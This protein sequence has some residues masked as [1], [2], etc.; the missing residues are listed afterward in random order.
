MI[1]NFSLLK[2][3]TALLGGVVVSLFDSETGVPEITPS[4]FVPPQPRD[5]SALPEFKLPY[6]LVTKIKPPSP[7]VLVLNENT[8]DQ[9]RSGR[10]LILLYILVPGPSGAVF[11]TAFRQ[12]EFCPA[13]KA[14]RS[15]LEVA[16][17]KTTIGD[18]PQIGAVF[19]DRDPLTATMLN[20]W[21][22]PS[23]IL[24]DS[25][26]IIAGADFMKI[27][28]TPEAISELIKGDYDRF[29]YKE[30]S[31]LLKKPWPL[32]AFF[33]RAA[34]ERDKA[35][36]NVGQSFYDFN[37][38]YPNLTTGLILAFLWAV[39]LYVMN[40]T[41]FPKVL[42]DKIA[43]LTT[44]ISTQTTTVAYTAAISSHPSLAEWLPSMPSPC[45]NIAANTVNG[46]AIPETPRQ[47]T[48]PSVPSAF[49]VPVRDHLADGP[50]SV[51]RLTRMR[52]SILT[53]H[54]RYTNQ[55]T[56]SELFTSRSTRT[57]A[58]HLVPPSTGSIEVQ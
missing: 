53:V 21:R 46:R 18:I 5:F 17:E 8:I 13:S 29:K 51:R 11:L 15:A 35:M 54:P 25:G 12:T 16:C 45:T 32:V 41:G 9:I 37:E 50:P 49:G 24:I 26:S 31:L 22:W 42:I 58:P 56:R 47:N 44:E 57:W 1:K 52:A 2:G 33:I 20:T 6:E 10:W 23:F 43:N 36:I 55:E 39:W 28:V 40:L 38:Q 7:S 19:F 14:F 30:A 48:A 4:T 34:N 27:G 3:F